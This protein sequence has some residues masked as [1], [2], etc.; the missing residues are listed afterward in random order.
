MSKKKGTKPERK[1]RGKQRAI[2]NQ[3]KKR[4]ENKMLG[5]NAKRGREKSLTKG[6]KRTEPKIKVLAHKLLASTLS[7]LML[8]P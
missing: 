1:R 6:N 2:K 4:K 7:Y 8:A 3:I 5:Q